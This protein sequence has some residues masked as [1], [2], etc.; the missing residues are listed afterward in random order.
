M[1]EK[2]PTSLTPPPQSDELISS[3]VGSVLKRQELID[4]NPDK[5]ESS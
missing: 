4:I 5:I 3:V 1:I 2:Q